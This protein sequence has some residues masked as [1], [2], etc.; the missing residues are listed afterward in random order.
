MFE[1][2]GQLHLTNKNTGR[3][4]PRAYVK[5]YSQQSG[6]AV[7]YKVGNETWRVKKEVKEECVWKI[8]YIHLTLTHT[9][10]HTHTHTQD[11][12]TDLRGRFDYASLNT[13]DQLRATSAFALLVMSDELGSLIKEVKPPKA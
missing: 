1:T 12:Y 7:F 6:K 13:N 9:H 10:T 3:A 4:V 8:M 11:G 2:H 5:V